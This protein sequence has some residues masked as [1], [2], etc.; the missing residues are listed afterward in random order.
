MDRSRGHPQVYC[1][2]S[3][4]G[5]SPWNNSGYGP[6]S[7]PISARTPLTDCSVERVADH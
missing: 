2:S 3:T 1:L 4:L 7:S 5:H 6:S